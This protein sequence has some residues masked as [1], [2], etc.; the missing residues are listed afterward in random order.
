MSEATTT[1]AAAAT[2]E[3]T[4]TETAATETTSAQSGATTTTASTDSA[5]QNGEGKPPETAASKVP[6]TYE[7]PVPEGFQVDEAAKGKA[8]ETFKRLGLTQ[9]QVKD[10][11]DTY[12]GVTTEQAKAA[13]AQSDAARAALVAEIREADRKV[14][15]ADPK[16]G[17]ENM[18]STTK[19]VRDLFDKFDPKGEARAVYE[20]VAIDQNRAVVAM[21]AS[22]QAEFRPDSFSGTTAQGSGLSDEEAL[23]RD[24]FPTHYAK[25][26]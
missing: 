19:A 18:L 15:M 4:T 8:V 2:T 11:W 20:Q 13:E 3:T 26:E 12:V 16:L 5:P 23:L 10:L 24:A 17:G 7:L 6:D 25:K 14:L 21:L 22:I 1:A 9:E